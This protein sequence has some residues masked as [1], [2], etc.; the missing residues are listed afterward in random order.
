MKEITENICCSEVK[1][2][3]GRESL[4]RLSELKDH[5]VAIIYSKRIN[6]DKISSYLSNPY[7][8]PIDDGEEAKDLSNIIDII[9]K[10][11]ER[12]FDRGDYI[13]AVGGG[14]IT[15]IA[16]FVASIYLRGLNLVNIPTTLLG[17]VDAA[18]GG[19]NGVFNSNTLKN[20]K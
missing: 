14:T 10:L 2:V 3:I 16:G 6:I 20:I 11:F 19:K 12:N 7:Y 18:I 8:I 13:V 4:S 9:K 1:I 15:D 17:M 5:N